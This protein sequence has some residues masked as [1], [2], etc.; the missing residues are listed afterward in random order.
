MRKILTAALILCLGPVSALAEGIRPLPRPDGLAVKDAPRVHPLRRAGAVTPDP[1][2]LV[3]AALPPLPAPPPLILP[4][5]LPGPLA[6]AGK[7]L[8]TTAPRDRLVE[9]APSEAAEVILSTSNAPRLPDAAAAALTFIVAKAPPVGPRARPGEARVE[10][11]AAVLPPL[12]PARRP[13]T[14]ARPAVVPVIAARPRVRPALPAPEEALVLTVVAA[15]ALPASLRPTKR[16]KGLSARRAP[17]AE[18]EVLVEAA[19]VRVRPGESLVRP[20]KGSVCGDPAIRGETI[21]PIPAK[22]KGCGIADPVRITEVDGVRLSTPATLDCDAARALK[23]WVERGLKPAASGAKV[24]GL[25]VAASYACRPRNNVRGAK[26]SEHGRGNAIDIAGIVLAD[27]RTLDV[28]RDYKGRNGAILRRAHKSAC[29]IF[30]TTLGP[31]SDGYHENHLHFDVA[32]Y[33]SGPY[34]R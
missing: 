23:K 17:A 27:G 28:L 20:K 10:L 16:P 26:V 5:V 30:G 9:A 18:P 11:A 21:P 13:D 3:E 32:A 22:V 7:V 4:E 8:V 1:A 31:G 29:G 6:E 2:A 24:K 12:R 15:A 19:A 25:V 34:C 14:V 33:R